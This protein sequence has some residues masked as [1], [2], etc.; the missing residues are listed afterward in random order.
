[1][2]L[3][4]LDILQNNQSEIQPDTFHGDTQSQN[5]PIFGLSYLLGI[6]LMPRIRNWKD[7]TLYRPSEDKKYKHI[8]GLFTNTIDWDLIESNFD[9]ML[10]VALSIKEGKITPSTILKKLGT[11]SRFKSI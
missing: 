4:L 2:V 6:N 7:L 9:S 11:Y 3:L 1:M 8:D 10:R 5:G